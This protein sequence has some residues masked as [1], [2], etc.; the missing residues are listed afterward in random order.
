MSD[1]TKISKTNQ[2]ITPVD[3]NNR[4]VVCGNFLVGEINDDWDVFVLICLYDLAVR[5]SES[6]FRGSYTSCSHEEISIPFTGIILL[7]R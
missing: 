4:W 7:D 5:D 6:H 3:Y 2:N 1:I